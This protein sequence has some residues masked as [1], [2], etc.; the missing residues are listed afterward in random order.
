MKICILGDSVAKGILFDPADCRYI[1]GKNGFAQRLSGDGMEVDNMSVFG[2]TVTKGLQLFQRHAKRL[3]GADVVLL[4]FGGNDCDYHWD[5]I[6]A[7]PEAEHVPNT[8]IDC[9]LE[10]YTKL[11]YLVQNS[12]SM[13]LVMNL[14]PIGAQRYFDR[15]SVNMDN[16]GRDNIIKWLGG[17]VEYIHRWHSIYN[18]RLCALTGTLGI[19]CADIRSPFYRTGNYN[20]YLCMDGIHPNEEGQKL[21]YDSLRALMPSAV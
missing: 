15:F 8:A 11:I 9:F 10:S 4:E 17:D 19:P 5:E 6:A 18:D 12:G 7:D 16:K 21:I 20:D 2:C 1:C 13:P 3:E 14:P